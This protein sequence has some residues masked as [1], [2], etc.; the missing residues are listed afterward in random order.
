MSVKRMFCWGIVASSA[1]LAVP[2]AAQAAFPG[3]NAQIAFWNTPG[4]A[5]DV[6]VINPDGTGLANLT[7]SFSVN[8]VAP[9]YSP[10]GTQIVFQSDRSGNNDIWRM[11]SA[12]GFPVD[13]TPTSPDNEIDPAFGPAVVGQKI[14]F[15]SDRDGGDFDIFVMNADGTGPAVNLTPTSPF[16]DIQPEFSPDGKRIV[17]TR[18]NPNLGEDI[19]IMNADGSGQT[20]LTPTPAPHESDPD[21][22]PD[23]K[24][25]AFTGDSGGTND[26]WTMNADGTGMVNLT[27]GIPGAYDV[28]PNYSPDGK[29]IAFDSYRTGSVVEDIFRMNVDGSSPVDLSGGP[30]AGEADVDPDWQPFNK[31]AKKKKPTIVGTDGPDILKGTKRA[32]VIVGLDG[33]DKL[34]GLGGK[35]VLCGGP[36]RDILIGGGGT[37]LLIGGKGQDR[38][39]GSSRDAVRQ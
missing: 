14:V 34:L 17:F 20:N 1:A 16:D 36:G 9:E 35:D 8:D 38:F 5:G 23:G 26:I 25:I 24:R 11:D 29:Q 13:L 6:E 21:F 4:P 37:D 27:G 15:A 33:A 22:S 28:T 18:R 2:T 7:S 10:T 3:T 32:D 31:C 39:K 12:G 30:T 19:W